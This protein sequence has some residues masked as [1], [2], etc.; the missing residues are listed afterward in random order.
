LIE[1]GARPAAKRW[2][3]NSWRDARVKGRGPKKARK[4]PEGFR[5][6]PPGV[7]GRHG[8]EDQGLEAGGDLA[9]AA[10]GGALPFGP[11]FRIGNEVSHFGS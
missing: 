9:R 5:I 2:E 7:L 10:V 6:G 8:V 1:A 4:S 11:A 3:R